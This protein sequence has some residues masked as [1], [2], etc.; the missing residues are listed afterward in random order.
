VVSGEP[1]DIPACLA[2]HQHKTPA[3]HIRESTL[4]RHARSTR[5]AVPLAIVAITVLVAGCG[6]GTR[7]QAALASSGHAY[8]QLM[9]AAHAFA[10]SAKA[11]TAAKRSLACVEAGDEAMSNAYAR[12][13][14]SIAAI[15]MPS[16]DPETAAAQVEQAATQTSH[17][18]HA[19]RTS[20][21]LT[22]YRIAYGSSPVLGDASVVQ[23]DYGYLRHVLTTGS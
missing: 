10:S 19:L 20:R 13:A 2:R 18:L 21:T 14:A 22:Q 11:C 15:P 9:N 16:G 3:R 7:P 17:A 4:M 1:E 12:F 5:R 23:E 6:G 8:A